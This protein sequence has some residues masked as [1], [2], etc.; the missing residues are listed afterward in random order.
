MRFPFDS[1]SPHS[2]D[3]SLDAPTDAPTRPQR[4]LG[5]DVAYERRT[6]DDYINMMN[7][8]VR[9]SLTDVQLDAV[10]RLV[11]AALPKPSPKLVDLRFGIDLL[12]S[13]FYVVVFVGKDRRQRRRDYVPSP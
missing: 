4:G 11:T 12:V 2:V 9:A 13:R 5:R 8:E 3:P 1:Q 7:A 6:A 10:H